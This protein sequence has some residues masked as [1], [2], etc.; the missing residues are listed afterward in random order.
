[1]KK[2][3]VL[4]LFVLLIGC[5]RQQNENCLDSFCVNSLE[6]GIE[7][8]LSVLNID[9]GTVDFHA[10]LKDDEKNL[11]DVTIDI[12]S[13]E[14][15]YIGEVNH[16]GNLHLM[17]S[18]H[19]LEFQALKPSSDYIAVMNG[20]VVVDGEFS[21]IGIAYTEFTTD[22]FSPVDISGLIDNIRVGSSFVVYDFEL[23]SNDFYIV[24]YGVFLYE[25]ETKLDE[26]TVWGSRGL[27]SVTSINQVFDNLD[28]N[29]TYT[30]RLDVIFELENIQ[31][32]ETIDEVIFT[33]D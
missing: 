8:T 11:R 7:G 31:N 6:Y 22:A 18:S 10:T 32:G 29:T 2:I 3:V 12:F 21:S 17:S 27:T 15:D 16:A 1:M 9:R 30:L 4:L 33:T 23:L 13:S 26:F 25:G 19:Q 24:S 5:S 28:A 20:T 14:W